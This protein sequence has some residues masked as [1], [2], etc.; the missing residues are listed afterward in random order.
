MNL[1]HLADLLISFYF[2]SSSFE[3]ESL[4]ILVLKTE[5]VVYVISLRTSIK[6]K[7]INME[8]L[9]FLTYFGQW[10][11]F[12]LNGPFFSLYYCTIIERFL[13]VC[14]YCKMFQS[15]CVFPAAVL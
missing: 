14:W 12:F 1:N 8:D 4:C 2:F 9:S 6:K 7:F 3:R 13:S 5:V 15:P 11:L 10:K